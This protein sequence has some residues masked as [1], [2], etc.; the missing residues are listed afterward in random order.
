MGGGGGGGIKGGSVGVVNGGR[1]GEEAV[2]SRM[3]VGVS[4]Q[5]VLMSSMGRGARG[6]G[7]RV[8]VSEE[9]VVLSSMGGAG[10]ERVCVR[11]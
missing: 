6:A 7:K 11:A 2:L 4:V 3:G 10:A 1:G 9:A 5:A 8:R